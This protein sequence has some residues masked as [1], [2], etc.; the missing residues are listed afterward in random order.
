MA[1]TPKVVHTHKREHYW[2]TQSFGRNYTIFYLWNHKYFQETKNYKDSWDMEVND[3]ITDN[4]SAIY[5]L[6]VQE[7]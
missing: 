2:G 6:Q 7:F 3:Y 5:I 1:R 4:Q